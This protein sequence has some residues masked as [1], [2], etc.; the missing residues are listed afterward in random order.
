MII[1]GWVLVV[2]GA[3]T[4]TILTIGVF[5]STRPSSL[6]EDIGLVFFFGNAPLVAGAVMVRIGRV[7]RRGKRIE[8]SEK[9]LLAIA[10]KN[11]GILTATLV[12]SET[13]LSIEEARSVLELF[14]TRGVVDMAIDNN[15]VVFYH[16]RELIATGDAG[17]V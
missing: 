15:G 10:R 13:P 17:T 8:S 3:L 12:A 14:V 2:F 5:A 16:F 11:K 9:L 7:R 6:A 4:T 1:A